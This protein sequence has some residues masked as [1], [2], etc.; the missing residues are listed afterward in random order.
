MHADHHALTIDRLLN[1]FRDFAG[2]KLAGA[3][4]LLVAAAVALVWANS[5][6]APSYRA[7]FDMPVEISAGP[8]EIKKSLLHWINDGLMGFFFFVVGL[9]IK[10]EVLAGH[11]RSARLAALP[12]AGALGG[13]IVPALAYLWL[14]PAET[15]RGWGVPMATDIAFALGVLAVL[16]ERVP[17]GLKVFLTALAIVDDIGAIIVIAL[18]YTESVAPLSL[19]AG[20]ALF[21]LATILNRAGVTS[22]VTYFILGTLVW[23]AFLKSGV[24]ATLAAVLMAFAIPARRRVDGGSFD[25]RAQ[26]LLRRLRAVRLP[27]RAQLLTHEQHD[28]IAAM[29]VL[30]A[31]TTAPLQRLEH[32]LVP[33]V[34]F[35]VL[36]AFALANAGVSVGE[37]FFVA[38][39]SEITLGIV[40]GLFV[41]KQAG[42]LGFAWAAVR[43]GLADLPNGAT[44][45]HIHGVAILGGIGFT[46]SLFIAA[47]AFPAPADEDLAKVGILVGSLVSAVVGLGVLR[48]ATG[49][50]ERT[51]AG[52]RARTS[53]RS[54]D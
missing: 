54:E 45:P 27:T 44:W 50:P 29:A 23:L 41:G 40:V 5:P 53:T 9:E 37:T 32:A 13:M 26:A 24:H 21:V 33:I 38:F 46:M 31:D 22:S 25:E 20:G 51:E 14:N 28:V 36:P 34:T 8:L 48:W 52:D 39:R 17:V 11:L 49:R 43:L 7:V 2:H 12:L 10:R 3:A 18:F 15:A 16:G 1:P 42:I 4:L 35:V 30:L 6:L 47:L 19:L